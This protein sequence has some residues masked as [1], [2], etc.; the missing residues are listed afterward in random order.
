MYLRNL[1]NP[2][3]DI[4]IDATFRTPIPCMVSFMWVT[5]EEPG[6]GRAGPVILIQDGGTFQ[7][8]NGRPAD[9][10]QPPGLTPAL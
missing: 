5:T 2:A 4:N 9:V 1:Q 8:E 6:V 10:T 7:M 3:G